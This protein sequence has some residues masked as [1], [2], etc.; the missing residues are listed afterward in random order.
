MTVMSKKE[1]LHK[2]KSDI[3]QSQELSEEL[4]QSVNIQR[5]EMSEL[6]E[7]ME[8]LFVE[9]GV[10]NSASKY[11]ELVQID[12]FNRLV[13]VKLADKS[14]EF[15]RFPELS[16][17]ELTVSALAGIVAVIIDVCFVGTPKTSD[18]GKAKFDGSVLTELVR[19]LGDTEIGEIAGKLSKKCKV[20]YDMVIP[21]GVLTP[22]LHRLKGL[23]HDPSFVGLCFA[24]MDIM[25]GTV[26]Y[27]DDMGRIRIIV[28]PKSAPSEEQKFVAL[29]YYVGHILSDMFTTRGIAIP[30]FSLL[31]LFANGGAEK[32]LA[33]TAESM[34]LN[35]YDVRHM[36]SMS[37][38]VLVKNL[39][40]D[41]YFYLMLPMSKDSTAPYFERELASVKVELK[42][43]KMLFLA[44]SVAVGGN[45]VKFLAPP[46]SGNPNALNMAEWIEFLYGSVD[47]L[48]AATRATG[49][50][51]IYF[52]RG[53]IDK[54]W[55]ELMSRK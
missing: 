54:N 55:D 25:L 1:D 6:N 21:G 39:V 30:G 8:A 5:S 12:E 41:A 53:Q 27:I 15:S 49:A 38:A 31:Q 4:R 11:T 2:F 7:R 36:V 37:T 18:K 14:E 47:M 9:A 29:L 42:R 43:V 33:K 50:E 22:N 26:T 16:G 35:G 45:L 46:A 13:D 34:Y 40:L 24:V 23:G 48:K 3:T 51:E 28:N 44:N 17:I 19:K 52:N 10:E 20:S 32:S